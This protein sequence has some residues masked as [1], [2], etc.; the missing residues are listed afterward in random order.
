METPPGWRWA[1]GLCR[2]DTPEPGW[3][4]GVAEML[5]THRV[6]AL[7]PPGLTSPHIP[8]IQHF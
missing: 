1:L 8:G 4:C 5:E 6:G 3:E 7:P 2:G